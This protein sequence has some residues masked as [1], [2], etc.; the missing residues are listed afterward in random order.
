MP[1]RGRPFLTADAPLTPPKVHAD[2]GAALKA[3]RIAEDI[4]L[5]AAAA[6]LQISS[7][8]LSRIEAGRFGAVPDLDQLWRVGRHY[9]LQ[10][11]TLNVILMRVRQAGPGALRLVSA[12]HGGEPT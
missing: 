5:H 11:S 8:S 12:R 2:Y 10:P 4:S 7:A 9:G 3:L 6:G 1:P